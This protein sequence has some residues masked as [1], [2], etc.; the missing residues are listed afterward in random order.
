MQVNRLYLLIS[1][2]I[3]NIQIFG[4]NAFPQPVAKFFKDSVKIGEP[5]KLSL[6]YAHPS[7]L[8]ILF[9]D[10]TFDF[11]PFEFISK[12][13]F[14]TTS[15]DSISKDSVIY[16]LSTFEIEQELKLALPVFI[17]QDGDTSTI[18]SDDASVKFKEEITQIAPNDSLRTNTDFMNLSNRINYPYI[19]IGTIILALIGLIIFIFFSRKI[20]ARYKLFYLEKEHRVFLEKYKKMSENYFLMPNVSILEEQLS[21]W[22]KYLQKIEKIPYTTLTTKEISAH[23]DLNQVR[24]SLQNFDRAIYGGMIREDMTSSIQYLL[25]IAQLKFE[26]RQNELRNI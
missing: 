12:T 6:V 21:L 15:K 13:Y 9:P 1:F 4:Q 20:I 10:S 23:L 5:I 19:G 18:Y 11:A 14:N 17:Y 25:D 7:K 22:K 16:T 24:S 26:K 3:F 8:E 2:F